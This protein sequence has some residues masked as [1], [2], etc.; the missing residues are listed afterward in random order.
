MKK[1][2]RDNPFEE[3]LIPARRVWSYSSLKLFR[4]CKRKYFWKQIMRLSPRREAESLLTSIVV[5][6]ALAKWYGS[7]KGSMKKIVN[8]LLPS[9]QKRIEENSVF[10]DQGE[11]EQLLIGLAT[12]SGMLLAYE[13]HYKDD[14]KLWEVSRQMVECWFQFPVSVNPKS[15]KDGTFDFRGKIDLLPTQKN[16]LLIVDHKIVGRIGESFVEK[17]QLDGQLRSYVLGVTRSLNQKPYKVVYNLV[18]KCKLRRKSQESADE[19]AARIQEDY[20]TR[21]DF[22]FQ[23]EPVRFSLEDVKDFEHDLRKTHLE[24]MHLIES[25]S[26]PLDPREW[27]CNDAACDEYF[28]LCEYFPLCTQCLDKGTGKMFTQYNKEKN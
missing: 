14:N 12:L 3:P 20:L 18:R 7:K 21:P 24:Y 6:E 11:Y 1:L 4:K 9:V 15:K 22:Y 16:K 10:Y 17:L 25:S 26:D 27:V 19:Y 8:R 28:R 5:H 23:R 13:K 2:I